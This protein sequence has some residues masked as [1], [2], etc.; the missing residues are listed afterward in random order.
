VVEREGEEV[1]SQVSGRVFPHLLARHISL[2]LPSLMVNNK[3]NCFCLST[4]RWRFYQHVS[5]NRK[6]KTNP[7]FVKNV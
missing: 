7:K 2:S 4:T 5:T 3:S 1:K 6:G